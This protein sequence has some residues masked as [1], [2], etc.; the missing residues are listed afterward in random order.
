[1]LKCDAVN[2][3]ID[4]MSEFK[5]FD[6]VLDKMKVSIDP[7]FLL[8]FLNFLDN[9]A[10]RSNV[11]FYN[12]NEIFIDNPS[13]AM[14]NN[15]LQLSSSDIHLIFAKNIS[16]PKVNI[17]L[18][19]SEIGLNEL[20]KEKFGFSSFSRKIIKQL[21]G[22]TNPIKLNEKSIPLF[23]GGFLDFIEQI[24]YMYQIEAVGLVNNI[25][26]RGIA[27]AIKNVF[28]GEES[29]SE[30]V[31]DK[32]L[33]PPRNFYGKY[34]YIKNFNYITA[35][36][37]K[38]I[39]DNYVNYPFLKGHYFV[40]GIQTNKNIFLF[41]TITLFIFNRSHKPVY[42][43]QIDYFCIQDVKCDITDGS[44]CVVFLSQ[45][46]D[47]TNYIEINTYI[48]GM[49]KIIANKLLEYSKLYKDEFSY[50]D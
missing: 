10:Y 5:K 43:K 3:P 44:V 45:I 46:I 2:Y 19:L 1:M 40:D 31:K 26:L 17:K 30:E 27:L 8:E 36:I 14:K 15:I 32:R 38:N 22:H 21:A 37:Q 50:L 33:R 47:K 11:K 28:R 6:F 4:N 13:N 41:T 24:I 18:Q 25:A 39:L 7:N 20:L 34:K 42:E 29:V 12:V 9:I 49:G 16:L 48:K 35:E 23:R